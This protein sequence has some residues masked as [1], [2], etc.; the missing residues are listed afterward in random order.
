[1]N[2]DPGGAALWQEVTAEHE[3]GTVQRVLLLEACRAK[4]RLDRFDALIR[5]E[6]ESFAE[7]PGI[8]LTVDNPDRLALA[9]AEHLKRSLAALQLPDKHGRRAPS[10][11][12]RGAYRPRQG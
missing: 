8:V 1:M 2:L 5:G 9:D 11:P 6:T 10:R 12:A 4:D 7:L 3:L